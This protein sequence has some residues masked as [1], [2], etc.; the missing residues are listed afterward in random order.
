MPPATLLLFFTIF[1]CFPAGK[2]NGGFPRSKAYTIELYR[3]EEIAMLCYVVSWKDA[4]RR[5]TTGKSPSAEN[6]PMRPTDRATA[7]PAGLWKA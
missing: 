4:G 2:G 1:L 5:V 3:A 6:D 7:R